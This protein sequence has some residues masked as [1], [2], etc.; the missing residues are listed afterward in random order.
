MVPDCNCFKIQ[1]VVSENIYLVVY[2]TTVGNVTNHLAGLNNGVN[3]RLEDFF[4]LS[5]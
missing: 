2:Y 3:E 4:S 5:H 1:S